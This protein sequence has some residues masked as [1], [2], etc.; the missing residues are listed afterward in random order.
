MEMKDFG[1]LV[2]VTLKGQKEQVG[3]QRPLQSPG[4]KLEKPLAFILPDGKF[5]R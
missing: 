5:H 3:V 4:G 1:L 2:Q